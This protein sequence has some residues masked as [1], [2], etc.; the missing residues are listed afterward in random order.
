MVCLFT[1]SPSLAPH[2][3]VFLIHIW[4]LGV[5]V[6][7]SRTIAWAMITVMNLF[8]GFLSRS[9]SI[10]SFRINPL[11]NKWMVG[12]VLLSFCFLILGIYVPGVNYIFDN[13]YF[14]GEGWAWVF[15]GL[16]AHIILTEISKAFYR[17][18]TAILRR[19]QKKRKAALRAKNISLTDVVHEA[20]LELAAKA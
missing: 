13:V 16:G 2:R 12:G 14:Y 17:G 10:S 7:T 18:H 6:P 4:I 11:T 8:Q 15:G 20:E 3:V 5:D 9:K 1:P 19:R